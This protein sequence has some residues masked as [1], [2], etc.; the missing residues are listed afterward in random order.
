MGTRSV[1][2]SLIRHA[3][4][5]EG[6]KYLILSRHNG[7]ADQFGL[8]DEEVP[9]GEDWERR[10]L[11]LFKRMSVPINPLLLATAISISLIR[12]QDYQLFLW[13]YVGGLEIPNF[14]DTLL[15]F[16]DWR[17]E[18]ELADILSLEAKYVE[19]FVTLG[20]EVL[21]AHGPLIAEIGG[22]FLEGAMPTMWDVYCG[23]WVAANPVLLHALKNGNFEGGWMEAMFYGLRI[24]NSIHNNIEY[25][26][27]ILNEV[28]LNVNNLLSRQSSGEEKNQALRDV[29][30]RQTN[31]TILVERAHRL[32]QWA[33]HEIEAHA[34]GTLVGL[35]YFQITEQDSSS[36]QTGGNEIPP[37]LEKYLLPEEVLERLRNRRKERN[38]GED[39]RIVYLPESGRERRT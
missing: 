9:P 16:T 28:N 12:N 3:A 33:P 29:L 20:T 5:V 18:D 34:A 6:L 1:D 8:L 11:S 15:R 17:D 14:E 4:P 31:R 21:V 13:H 10:L 38:H 36:P 27:Y 7:I 22:L 23:A 25:Y 24:N 30:K 32:Y 39:H 2:L 35:C 19:A 37:D 26:G